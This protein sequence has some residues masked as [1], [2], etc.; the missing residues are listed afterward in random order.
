MAVHKGVGHYGAPITL[1][2]AK[3]VIAAA[4]AKAIENNCCI[5]LMAPSSPQFASPKARLSPRL[6]F[7]GRPKPWRMLSRAAVRT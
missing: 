1:D 6:N 7:A 2:Q 5:A 4:E 3:K